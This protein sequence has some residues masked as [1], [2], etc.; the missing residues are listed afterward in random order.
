M[1]ERMPPVCSAYAI[2]ILHFLYE[3]ATIPQRTIAITSF[4]MLTKQKLQR[5]TVL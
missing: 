4:S 5:Q 1:I 3:T 2:I